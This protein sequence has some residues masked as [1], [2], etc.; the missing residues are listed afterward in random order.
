MEK[1]TLIKDLGPQPSLL[2][3]IEGL[4]GCNADDACD[5]KIPFICPRRIDL[6]RF[7]ED[8]CWDFDVDCSILERKTRRHTLC[9][10]KLKG[11]VS[12]VLKTLEAIQQ[13]YQNKGMTV[14]FTYA[15]I[16]E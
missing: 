9:K 12:D 14:K 2:E 11:T 3:I 5:A 1:R 6:R 10:T 15:Q 4:R 13:A 8:T 16:D 7:I